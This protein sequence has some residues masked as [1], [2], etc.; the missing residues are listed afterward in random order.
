MLLALRV[1]RTRWRQL[2]STVVVRGDNVTML[3]M[4]LQFNGSSYGLNVVAS[5]VALE[6]AD[7]AYRPLVAEHVPGV[8]N[9]LADA[10]SRV[11]DP[12]KVWQLPAQLQGAVRALVPERPR[13]WYRALGPLVAARLRQRRD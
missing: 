1:W 2:R 5:E 12:A 9:T 3:T 11:S 4:V 6:L 8:A 13:A 10:L 7:A